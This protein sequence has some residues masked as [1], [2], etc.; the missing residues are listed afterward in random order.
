MVLC[1]WRA[2][3]QSV[4]VPDWQRDPEMEMEENVSGIFL[5]TGFMLN[6]AC[7]RQ[8]HVVNRDR[9][10]RSLIVNLF[11]G[12]IYCL[13]VFSWS[14]G[15]LY[16]FLKEEAFL[17]MLMHI[18]CSGTLTGRKFFCN[19]MLFTCL[20]ISLVYLY[21]TWV[22][23]KWKAYSLTFTSLQFHPH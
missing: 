11:I 16:F 14:F 17:H 22:L 3:E 5:I 1:L 21:F 8:Q 10:L 7:G 15:F 12:I 4:K 19:C 6:T 23:L 13:I 18:S 2:T 20:S 9:T